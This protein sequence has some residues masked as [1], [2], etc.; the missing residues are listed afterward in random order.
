M[1]RVFARLAPF[2]HLTRVTTAFAAVANVWFVI[3]W[4]RANEAEGSTSALARTP[5]WAAL[6]SGAVVAVGLYAFG[7][8]LNDV[9]DIRR[10][11]ALHPE[12]PIPSGRLSVDAAVGL[13]AVAL[14]AAVLGSTLLG[15]PAV[16]MCLLTAGAILAFNAGARFVPSVGIVSLSLIYGAHMMIP[17]VELVFVWPVWLVMTHAILIA[18]ATHVLAGRRPRLTRPAVASAIAGWTFWSLVL[19]FVGWRRVGGLWPEWVHWTAAAGPLIL[20]A[21][22]LL[23]AVR[24]V[25]RAKTPAAAADKLMRYGALWLALYAAAW[26]LGQGQLREGIM[27][28]VLAAVGFLGMTILREL[29][30]LIEQPVGY[31]R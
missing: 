10:D 27:L 23:V 7:A 26:L 14:I 11:R 6:A 20:A 3:L 22:F 15:I 21:L 31:R 8:A 30:G 19:L 29:Y 2:L 18:A 17:N 16:L 12:R 13:V 5:E 24:K 4:T 25:K 9:L 28:S 1:L